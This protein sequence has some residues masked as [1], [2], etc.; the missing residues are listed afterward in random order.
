MSSTRMML[1][2]VFFFFLDAFYLSD[3]NIFSVSKLHTHLQE[4]NQ[5]MSG[6]PAQVTGCAV[7]TNKRGM[8]GVS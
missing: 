6:H 2:P 4:I 8:R 5:F 7:Y 3:G 1:G